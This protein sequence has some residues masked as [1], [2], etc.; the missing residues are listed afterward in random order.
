MWHTSGWLLGAALLLGSSVQQ[1]E[2]GH[3][4]GYWSGHNHGHQHYGSGYR[5]NR[6]WSVGYGGY[7]RGF[8]GGGYYGGPFVGRGA[9]VYL[10]TPQYYAPPVV[11]PHGSHYH[12]IPGH[13]NTQYW[14]Y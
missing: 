13:H 12:V 11:V 8:V 5:V 10:N 4:H 14:G 9:P 7:G 3:G 6:G 2:A 1:V